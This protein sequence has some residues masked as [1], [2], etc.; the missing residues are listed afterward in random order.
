RDQIAPRLRALPGV[1]TVQFRSRQQVWA[2]QTKNYSIDISGIPN[3]MND[4]FILTLSD[5][6]QAGKIAGTVRGWSDLVQEVAVP[7]DELNGVRRIA[8]FLRM[9]GGIGGVILLLGA[10]LVVSNTIRVS[11]AARRREIKIMQI[12]GASPWFIRLPLLLEGLIHGVL[13]G[14]LA[15]LCLYVVGRSVGT[16]IRDTVPMLLPYGGPIDA[17]S[18]ALSLIG[19]G[20]VLGA[21]GSF[22]SIHRY[23]RV[24]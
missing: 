2:E 9:I 13:G 20:A 10:L 6:E 24:L 7:E 23:L 8:N 16:L 19:A 12:V 18:L 22:L 15:S 3:Q 14:A 5:P 1:A 21:G 17:P 11:V 4:T